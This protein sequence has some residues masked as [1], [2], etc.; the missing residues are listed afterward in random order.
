MEII[1]DLEPVRQDTI[2][3]YMKKPG[4]DLP[5]TEGDQE[6]DPECAED[7]ETFKEWLAEQAA[8]RQGGGLPKPE[9]EAAKVS[10]RV[11]GPSEPKVGT[12]DGPGDKSDVQPPQR[13]A[14]PTTSQLLME[15][16]ARC[17][18]ACGLALSSL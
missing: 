13:G 1:L 10:D 16:C 2:S 14:T 8:P 4:T 5:A 11:E 18:P 15:P 17:G 9:E 6:E 3:E 12:S 7:V